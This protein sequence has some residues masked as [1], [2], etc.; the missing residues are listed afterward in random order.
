MLWP[1]NRCLLRWECMKL[2][3]FST[4]RRRGGTPPTFDETSAVFRPSWSI[5][6]LATCKYLDLTW[7]MLVDVRRETY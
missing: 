5:S 7:N 2:V 1:L 6:F 3:T 4:V